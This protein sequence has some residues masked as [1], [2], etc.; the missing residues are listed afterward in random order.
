MHNLCMKYINIHKL[1]EDQFKRLTGISWSTYKMMIDVLNLHL[2]STG[3]PS[4]LSIEDQLLL[5]LS[6][7][8]EYRTLFHVGMTYGV[9]EATAS[10]IVRYVEDC[11][12]RSNKFNLPKKLPAS[13]GLD[14]N[15]VIV[16]ATE[17]IVQY[18]K[19]TEEKL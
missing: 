13:G 3:R 5:C 18:P 11:L 2:S 17:I 15:I 6:Y 8:H 14:W 19:E 10:I 16:D 12:I 9:S 7:W 4:K 1:T